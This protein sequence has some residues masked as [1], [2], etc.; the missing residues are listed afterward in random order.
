MNNGAYWIEQ[1]DFE[2]VGDKYKITYLGDKPINVLITVKLRGIRIPAETI[3]FGFTG[4]GNW[5]IPG[6]NYTGCNILELR[7]LDDG[8]LLFNKVIDP[9]IS[10]KVKKQNVICVG[11]NKTGTSSF[12]SSLEKIGFNRPVESFMFHTCAQDVFHGDFYTTLS[13]LENE[14][15][16]LYRDL[17]FSI[18]GVY[19]TLYKHR[20]DDIYVLTVRENIDK[21]VNS[22]INFY[23]SLSNPKMND[24]S[25]LST[26]F[27]NHTEDSLLNSLRVQ[28]ESWGID[29]LDNLQEKLQKVYIKHNNDV[30]N[31][32][33]QNKSNFIVLDV[34]KKG[35]FKSFCNW[36]GIETE[37]EDFDWV[38]KNSV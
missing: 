34:S 21:W 36:M 5:F 35:E 13:S 11:L 2:I 33:S 12:V 37:Q 38:N 25:Y 30:I 27:S 29:N 22:V 9:K 26:T 8:S 10:V 18:P 3:R 15:Y 24:S 23:P 32:F 20:P 19:R 14:R 17:P 7:N 28:F 31:F 4:R 6:L 16:N 1:F